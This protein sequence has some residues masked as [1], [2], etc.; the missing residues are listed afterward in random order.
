[1]RYGIHLNSE[2]NID[3][4]VQKSVEA[5]RLGLD[6]VWVCDMP[7]QRYVPVVASAIASKTKRIRIG[8]GLSPFLHTNQQIVSAFYSLIKAYGDRFELCLIPGDKN[9]LRTVGILRESSRGISEFLVQAK[10][11]I[12]TR[13]KNQGLSFNIGLGAQGPKTLEIAHFFDYVHLNICSP[14]IIEWAMNEIQK[15]VGREIQIG[16]FAPSYV[17]TV[18]DH[19]LYK[20]LRSSSVAIILGASK[21]FLKIFGFYRELVGS[22]DKIPQNIID[23]FSISMPSQK[24]KD[25]LSKIESLGIKSTVFSYPQDYSIDTIR[26]LAKSLRY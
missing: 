8:L 12:L 6:S 10:S 21:R 18:Y 19:A 26:D 20:L 16:I 1:M 22:R 9:Q 17:Y 25:Y 14:R 3:Q 2:S 7:S 13:S 24:L 15:I 23:E 4:V 5:E 11:E